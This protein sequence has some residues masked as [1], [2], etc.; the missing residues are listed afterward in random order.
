M[1][2]V[3]LYETLGVLPTAMCAD[4]RAEHRIQVDFQLDTS[5]P[6]RDLLRR[7]DEAAYVL[8][9]EERRKVYDRKQQQNIATANANYLA[10]EIVQMQ[11]RRL[12][13]GNQGKNGK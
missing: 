8:C 9:D 13:K 11:R 2:A 4:I 6:D 7:L 3:S 5:E 10:G 1:E 12:E